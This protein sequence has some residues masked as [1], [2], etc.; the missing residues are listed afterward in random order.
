MG[1]ALPCFTFTLLLTNFVLHTHLGYLPKCV[2][3]E[4]SEAELPLH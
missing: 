1:Y 2:E 4:F 3:G